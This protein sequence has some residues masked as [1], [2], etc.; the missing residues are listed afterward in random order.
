MKR[1]LVIGGGSAGVMFSNRMRNEFSPDEVEITVIERNEMHVY[2]P[3]FTLVVFDLDDPKNLLRPVK[4]LFFDGIK[5]I[6]DIAV[7]ID[8]DNNKVVTEK[9]GEISYD[10]LVIASGA[11]LFFEEPEGLKEGIEASK[12]VFTFYKL[13]GAIKL[14][15]KLKDMDG[16]TIAMSVCEMPIKCPAAPMKFIMMAE[17]TMRQRGKRNK[18][19]FV[20][21]T[22]MP[23]VFSREPY[24]SKLV[25]IFGCRGIDTVANFAPSEVDSDKGVIKDYGGK[26]VKFDLLCI[27]PPHGG[28]AVIE[29]SEGVGDAA[30]WVSCDKNLMVSK[31]FKNVYGIGDATDFPTSKTASGIRKQAKVLVS[32]LKSEIKGEVPTDT[33][34]GEIICPILTRHKRVM[35]AHF[36]YEESISPAIESYGNWVLKVHMLRPLYW[37]LML[38]GLV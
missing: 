23:A 15:D 2:Q 30:G 14:R 26:E 19:K 32:R 3:A 1:I 37:N 13:D 11:K 18:F 31:K 8:A 20:F 7:K 34:D 9:H 27:T 5:L 24:A 38:N 29:E 33:Y 21:T 10:Y 16:G 17:D 36:N 28:E 22:P 35:F 6:H 4:D 12:N 25:S